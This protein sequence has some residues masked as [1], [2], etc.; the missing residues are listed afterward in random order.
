MCGC[1]SRAAIWISRRNRSPPS[2]GGELGTEH[3]DGDL[4][5]VPQVL[6]QVDGGHPALPELALEQV[7]GAQRPLQSFTQI[8]RYWP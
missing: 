6:G 2:G 7:A 5:L 8:H 4:P 3:L 1:C